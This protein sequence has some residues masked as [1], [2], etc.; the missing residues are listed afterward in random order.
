MR[1]IGWLVFLDRFRQVAH[2]GFSDTR[3]S[4]VV[5]SMFDP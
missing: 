5:P 2:I 4:C 1:A 3:L